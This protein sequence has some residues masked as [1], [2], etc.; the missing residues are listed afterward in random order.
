M[1][2]EQLVTVIARMLYYIDNG[3][4]YTTDSKFSPYDY[5]LEKKIINRDDRIT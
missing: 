3:K 1:T 4:F 2:R 5:L